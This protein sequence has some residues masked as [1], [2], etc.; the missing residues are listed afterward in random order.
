MPAPLIYGLISQLIR[1]DDGDDLN[2][3][4]PEKVTLNPKTGTVGMSVSES[5]LPMGVILYSTILT[6]L[7][8]IYTIRRKH[9]L[10]DA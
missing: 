10:E 9:R 8:I 3:T 4:K 5:H 6:N 1:G 7:F 2:D